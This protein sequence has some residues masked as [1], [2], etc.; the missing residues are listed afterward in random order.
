VHPEKEYPVR[1]HKV[2]VSLAAASILLSGCASQEE[3][4]K[5][6]VASAESAVA[7]LRVDAAKYAPEALLDVEARLAEQKNALA[8][9]HYKSVLAGTSALNTSVNTLRETV[10][11]K[12]T[13]IAA[14][15]NEWT[16]LST[17]V[18]KMV[19]DI[20]FRVD[21][22]SGSKLPEGVNK[23]GFEAAKAALAMM[24]ATWAEATA[25]FSAGNATE[26][27]DK[28]RIV[29]AKAE[30]VQQQLAMSPA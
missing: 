29:K 24:K 11:A 30:E 26:A 21:Y 19:K 4:A 5:A 7:E 8:Q 27:A 16:D 12:K 25:A 14:S 23:E 22:L 15:T 1:I 3:P 6:A 18:P 2:F 20:Q 10:V 13:Q 28:A 9:E 17:E